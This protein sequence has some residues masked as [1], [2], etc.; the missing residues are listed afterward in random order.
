MAA[1]GTAAAYAAIGPTLPFLNPLAQRPTQNISTASAFGDQRKNSTTI[2]RVL[3]ATKNA[4][5]ELSAHENDSYYLSTS[6]GNTG[7]NGAGGAIGAWDCWHPNGNP[8]SNG[9]AYM[10]CTGFVVAVLEACGA[11]CDTIGNYVGSAGYNRGNKSNLYRWIM[12]LEDHASLYTR[13]ESKAEL[14]KSGQLKKGDLIIAN[15]RDW[16]V[17]DVDCHI[18]F[19]WG[20]SSDHDLAWHSSG[21]GDDVIAGTCPG[22]MISKIT[23]KSS[24]VYWLHA[25]LENIVKL[26]IEKKSASLAIATGYEGAPYYSLAN[27]KFEIYETCD[28]GVCANLI[29]EFTTDADGCAEIEIPSSDSVWILEK[30]APLG[31]CKYENPIQIELGS[32]N[33]SEAV[34]DEPKQVRVRVRK[35]DAETG[36]KPQGHASLNGAVFEL[37]DRKGNA[38][39][40]TTAWN[41]AENAWI[42]EFPKIAR[43]FYRLREAK[44]PIGYLKSPLEK[45]SEDDWINLDLAPEQDVQCALVEVGSIEEIMRSDIEGG[46]FFTPEGLE[47]NST[48]TPLEGAEFAI[49]LQEDGT[50]REKGYTV[51][52]ITGSDGS[53]LRTPLGEIAYGAFV[54]TIRSHS[55]GKFTSKDLLA[56]WQPEKH[57]GLAAPECALAYGTYALVE[58]FC[59]NP[60]LRL[61]DPI[62]NI[63]VKKDN[64][65]VFII[66]EDRPVHS[67]VRIRKTDAET[68]K[69]V[70]TSGME[71][72]LLRRNSSGDYQLV[73]FSLHAPDDSSISRFVIPESG[74][75]QFPDVLPWGSYGIREVAAV[76]PYLVRDDLVYFEVDAHHDWEEDEIIVIDLPNRQA[77]GRIKGTKVDAET[78]HGVPGGVFIAYAEEDIVSPDGTPALNAGDFAGKAI[79]DETGAWSIDE[80]PL[81]D[82][83]ANYIVCESTAPDGYVLSDKKYHITLSWEN[84][85]CEI[86]DYEMSIDEQPTK[87]QITKID[88]S[89]KEAIEGVVF[90]LEAIGS[91]ANDTEVENKTGN[92]CDEECPEES[93]PIE[94]TTNG[95]GVAEAAYLKH[96]TLYRIKEAST[97]EDLGYICQEEAFERFLGRDGRWYDSEE[98]CTEMLARGLAGDEVWTLEIENDFTSV[99]FYK[100]D[101]ET[102]SIAQS[103]AEEED[104]ARKAASKDSLTGGIFILVDEDGNSIKP[105]TANLDADGWQAQGNEGVL[106]THLGVGKTYTFIEKEAPAGYQASKE[107]TS[108]SIERTSEPKIVVLANKKIE[109]I[110]KTNDGAPLFAGGASLVLTG[111]LAALAAYSHRRN[112]LENETL[113]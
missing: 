11:D 23:S 86:V 85:T 33:I 27:A 96:G 24:D 32:A 81:G 100:V 54:G 88:S 17:P 42:A 65:P 73:E 93:Q 9:E 103:D 67:P 51:S 7:P 101:S 10:N 63:E 60:S 31:F 76:A 52:P 14:L 38:L 77:K 37:E 58:T 87:V 36:E 99:V 30:E 59:P 89:S 35:S 84:D 95:E 69:T 102:W 55:D 62:F 75:V 98:S 28:N 8:K 44:A 107:R 2:E 50:L 83:I 20:S 56:S 82:G 104:K 21:H 68:G 41:E 71:I 61:A 34:T 40:A 80:M 79:S 43:G 5:D 47:E 39:T 105:D 49:W 53:A 97:R 22:N 16:S 4:L 109:R 12:Y 45:A 13:Y 57:N 92:D 1:A 110:A 15:P 70:L 78:G 106:F 90:T 25:P 72:E 111:G 94:L 64:L 46:K 74:I 108:I 6:Y 3:G 29:T 19:F 18:M 113:Q 112:S 26:S 91:Q 48:K 66:I